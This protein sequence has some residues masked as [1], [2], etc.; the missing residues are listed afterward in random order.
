M[1][2]NVEHAKKQVAD[3]IKDFQVIYIFWS[4]KQFLHYSIT[5]YF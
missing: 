3:L 1:K 4:F 2:Y 5:E